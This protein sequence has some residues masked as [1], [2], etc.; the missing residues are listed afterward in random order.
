MG[1]DA[2]VRAHEYVPKLLQKHQTDFALYCKIPP[3][4]DV[5]AKLQPGVTFNGHIYKPL[6]TRISTGN[7][8]TAQTLAALV[9]SALITTA[10]YKSRFSACHHS[11][12][13]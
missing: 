6:N 10:L 11:R 9:S 7:T 12:P 2:C 1:G 13:Q 5:Y 4:A 8:D 3:G